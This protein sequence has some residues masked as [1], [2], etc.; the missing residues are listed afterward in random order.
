MILFYVVFFIKAY[1]KYKNA[2]LSLILNKHGQS[3]YDL[4]YA[5]FRETLL[6]LSEKNQSIFIKH[7]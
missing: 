4:K 7:S 6:K 5:E 3:L 2:I 1:D